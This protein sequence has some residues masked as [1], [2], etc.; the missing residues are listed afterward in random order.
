MHTKKKKK[1]KH[2]GQFKISQIH[3]RPAVTDRASSSL[4]H[5]LAVTCITA[6]CL[7]NL[8]EDV[9]HRF[10]DIFDTSILL[11]LINFEPQEKLPG[12]W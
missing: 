11:G 8:L 12:P 7:L 10:R 2:L 6:H 4:H 3:K 1:L 5:Q 9:L